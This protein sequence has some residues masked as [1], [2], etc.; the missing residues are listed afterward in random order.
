MNRR[1]GCAAGV[2]AF[3]GAASCAP[4]LHEVPSG[5]DA[6]RRAAGSPSAGIGSTRTRLES[7]RDAWS[8]RPD[9]RAVREAEVAYLD[10]AAAGDDAEECL[11]G[12][13]RAKAWLTEHEPDPA[14]REALA[15]SAVETGQLCRARAPESAR[16]A[17]WLAIGLGLQARERPATAPDGIRRMIE[18]LQEAAER[19]RALDNGGPHRVLALVLMRAP[20]WPLGPGDAEAALEAAG[21]AVEIDPAYPPNL[22]ALAE[23]LVRNRRE[24]VG[25]AVYGD[26]LAAARGRSL[27]LEP[28]AAAWIAEAEAALAR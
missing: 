28:D 7:A 11:A 15:V 18:L 2:L 20:G 14:T 13:L 19:D 6:I 10:A 21:R 25:R 1:L 23:A 27:A 4:A 8:R 3:L 26:A 24:D 22:L 12:A 9:P 16:C 5:P 17:Y